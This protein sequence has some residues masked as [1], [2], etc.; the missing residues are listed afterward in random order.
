MPQFQTTELDF[1][2]IKTNLKT[3]FKRSDSAF[4]DW[5]FEGSGLN[6][7]LDVL[8]YNT[9][10]NAITAHM[11]MNESFLDSAQVRSNVVSRA[12]L[13]GYTPTSKTG[14]TASVNVTFDRAAGSDATTYTMARGTKFTTIIDGVTYTFQTIDDTTSAYDAIS[15]TFGFSNVVIKQGVTKIQTF[16]I[17]NSINQRFVIND[18]N[19]DTSTLIVK[20]FDSLTSTSYDIFRNFKSFTTLDSTSRVYYLSENTEG[21]YEVEFGN[22]T[23]GLQPYG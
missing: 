14:P 7:L 9:H 16:T 21:K 6:N 20:V 10:Y 11:A 19:I 15:N 3:Y 17:N 18:K 4:K 1:D 8:A 22:N 5:D 12:R 13:L 2:Q 23:L